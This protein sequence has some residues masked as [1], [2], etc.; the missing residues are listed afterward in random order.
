MLACKMYSIFRRLVKTDR[1]AKSD[2]YV[3]LIHRGSK[4]KT[5]W[6]RSSQD[7]IYNQEFTL[8]ANLGS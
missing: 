1:F 8:Y 2:P 7:P 5:S 3:C 4:Q 6:I